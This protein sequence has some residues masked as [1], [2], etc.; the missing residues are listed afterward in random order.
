MIQSISVGVASQQLVN[1]LALGSIYAMIAVGLAMIY[2]VLRVLHIAH[3]GIYTA[4]AY[5]GLYF[6]N[7]TGN[8]LVAIVGA[9]VIAGVLGALT[10]RFIYRPM[11]LKPRIVALIAS[12]GMFICLSDLFRILAGPH[13][14]AF[15]VSALAGQFRLAEL[16]ISRADLLIL[17]GTALSFA[18]LW[19]V[20]RHTALGFAIRAVAQDIETA[21]VMGIDVD[22]SVQAVF[23]LGSAIAALGGIMVA[24]LYNAVYTSMGDVVAYKGLALIVIGGFGSMTGAALA[25]F[26]LGITETALTTYTQIP[27]SR[28]G[29]AMLLLVI[30]ILVRPQGLL[31]KE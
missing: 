5:L 31:G 18:A 4:G 17:G 26:L 16:T 3:A 1:A 9:M 27:L 10:E 14:L 13:Q 21:K 30:L 22:R 24:I 2:G 25:S 8:L 23:F 15:D 11:L 29:I 12:I 6:Y 20:V 19:L 28:D 7:Q